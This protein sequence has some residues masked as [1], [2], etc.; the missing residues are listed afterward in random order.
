[1]R[2]DPAMLPTLLAQLCSRCACSDATRVSLIGYE[3]PVGPVT[4]VFAL[5]AL[6][7]APPSI[8]GWLAR[9]R[10]AAAMR[11]VLDAP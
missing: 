11:R 9:R 4:A 5:T 6:L 7:F 8:A 2:V 1:M 3:V 10:A